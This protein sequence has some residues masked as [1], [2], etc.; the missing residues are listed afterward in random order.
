MLRSWE[1]S[2]PPPLIQAHERKRRKEQRKKKNSSLSDQVF[3]LDEEM[4]WKK[5]SQ[6]TMQNPRAPGCAAR[7]LAEPGYGS[8]RA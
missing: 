8:C 4:G 7:V 2:G 6:S 5:C 1:S 3:F